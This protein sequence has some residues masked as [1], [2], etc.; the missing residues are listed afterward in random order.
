MDRHLPLAPLWDNILIQTTAE[1]LW[2]C[3]NDGTVTTNKFLRIIRN[4]AVDLGWLPA[5]L[6][7]LVVALLDTSKSR[8]AGIVVRDEDALDDA[9]IRLGTMNLVVRR[10]LGSFV[11]SRRDPS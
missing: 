11:V 8:L 9:E 6:P 4:F 2:S 10:E 5:S 7:R 3:L 1:D